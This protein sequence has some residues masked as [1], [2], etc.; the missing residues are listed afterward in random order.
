MGRGNDTRAREVVVEW[1]MRISNS[2]SVPALL[3]FAFEAD[4]LLLQ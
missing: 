4:L 2:T 1:I 3:K